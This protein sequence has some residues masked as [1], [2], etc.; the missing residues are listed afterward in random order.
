MRVKGLM[1]ELQIGLTEYS[2]GFIKFFF[3]RDCLIVIQ[4]MVNSTA[5]TYSKPTIT[6]DEW[7]RIQVDRYE[8]IQFMN[9]KT[10]E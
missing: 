1:N 10:F 9:D 6:L 8:I 7:K 5:T 3:V 2:T 4:M